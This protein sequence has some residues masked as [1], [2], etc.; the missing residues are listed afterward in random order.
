MGQT[1]TLFLSVHSLTWLVYVIFCVLYGVT[2]VSHH[3]VQHTPYRDGIQFVS[4]KKGTIDV[5]T[6][7]II[8][9]YKVLFLTILKYNRIIT[10][11]PALY[12]IYVRNFNQN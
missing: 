8:T 11:L 2:G 4:R 9:K 1:F 10:P 12:Y 7:R 3:T 6:Q 5:C